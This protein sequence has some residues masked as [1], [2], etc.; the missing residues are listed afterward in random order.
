LRTSKIVLSYLIFL[1]FLGCSK[2]QTSTQKESSQAPLSTSKV[3]PKPV[4]KTFLL[5]DRNQTIKVTIKG[6]KILLQPREKPLDLLLFFTSWCPS[7]KAQ[8]PELKRLYHSFSNDLR[9]VLIGLDNLACEEEFQGKFDFFCSKSYK[10]N[11][12]LAKAV[13]N[14]LHAGANMPIPLML[15]LKD[16]EYVIHYVGAVPYEILSFDIQRAKD[17]RISKE[18]TEAN[19]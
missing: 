1:I 11:E 5:Q 18:R 12:A 3:V 4:K 17:A 2:E 6:D 14:K 16:G 19:R 15:V 9:V 7:C 13:Y 8:I 10:E